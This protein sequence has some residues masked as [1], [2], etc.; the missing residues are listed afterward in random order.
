M[1][2]F[3]HVPHNT[4][5][6]SIKIT[7][8]NFLSPPTIWEPGTGYVL[9]I[10]GF[11]IEDDKKRKGQKK[12]LKNKGTESWN[13][14]FKIPFW[15][16]TSVRFCPR[17]FRTVQQPIRDCMVICR[18]IAVRHQILFYVTETTETSDHMFA[19]KQNLAIKFASEISPVQIIAVFRNTRPVKF[20]RQLTIASFATVSCKWSDSQR[21]IFTLLNAPGFE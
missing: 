18:Y 11:L 4:N 8:E 19:S 21:T 15:W 13:S 12:I 7:L 9:P 17:K 1:C 20:K 3:I 6:N 10:R 2:L 14:T 5:K 16:R